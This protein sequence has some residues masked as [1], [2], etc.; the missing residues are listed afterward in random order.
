VSDLTRIKL[1][2]KVVGGKPCIRGL[3]VT[4]ST[5]VGLLASGRTYD[6]ILAKY[7]Y[8]EGDDILAAL[9]WAAWRPEEIEIPPSFQ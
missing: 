8:L 7:P 9:V 3:R 5:I 4:G 6:E 2:P 1:D